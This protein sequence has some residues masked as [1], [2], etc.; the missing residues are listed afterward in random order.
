MPERKVVLVRPRPYLYPVY[1]LLTGIFAVV[2][3]LALVV[4]PA[5]SRKSRDTVLYCERANVAYALSGARLPP[6]CVGSP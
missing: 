3:W 1:G 4:V 6:E 5:N 2:L